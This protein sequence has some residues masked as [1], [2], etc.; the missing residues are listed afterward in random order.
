MCVRGDEAGAARLLRAYASM[1]I[2]RKGQ[3]GAAEM[4]GVVV[5]VE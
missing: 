4:L 2:G 5:C 1:F 3:K